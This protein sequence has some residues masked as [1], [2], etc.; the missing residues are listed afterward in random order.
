[1]VLV[2]GEAGIG[3]SSLVRALPDRLPR[4]ARVLV[5]QCDDLAARRPLGP[6]RALVGS[7]GAELARAVT[8]GGDRHRVHEAL[9]VLTYRDDE[10]SRGHPLRIKRWAIDQNIRPG[11]GPM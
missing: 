2:F 4:Q 10:L 1:M 5:G 8:E 7:V 6:F 9:L 11:W 3:K